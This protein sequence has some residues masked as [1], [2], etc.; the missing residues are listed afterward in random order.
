[1]ATSADTH[2]FPAPDYALP[3]F[4]KAA[5]GEGATY[6]PYVGD[7]EVRETLS[8]NIE[9]VLGLSASNGSSTLLSPGTQGS[10]FVALASILEP[11]DTVILPDPDYLSTE[12]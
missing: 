6:T 12:R 8:K 11:G 2:R 5:K 1:D 3:A 10:I 9:D 4:E 7:P